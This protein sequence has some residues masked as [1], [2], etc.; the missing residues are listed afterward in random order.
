MSLVIIMDY[1]KE[2]NVKTAEVL[3]YFHAMFPLSGI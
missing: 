1:T 3:T 2:D